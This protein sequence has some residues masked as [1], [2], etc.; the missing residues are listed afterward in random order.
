MSGKV[1]MCANTNA[2][3]EIYKKIVHKFQLSGLGA[4]NK[5][6]I[7]ITAAAS[8]ESI[9]CTKFDGKPGV[10][11]CGWIDAFEKGDK[12]QPIRVDFFIK[13][14]SRWRP[15][16]VFANISKTDYKRIIAQ[17]PQKPATFQCP[18]KGKKL[19][20]NPCIQ[21]GMGILDMDLEMYMEFLKAACED[22]KAKTLDQ[23]QAEDMLDMETK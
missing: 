4:A 7:K 2:F 23:R 6:S 21:G 15:F 13:L 9:E 5:G 10:A 14:G 19:V 17:S 18:N 3:D 12:I 1:Y 8:A 20:F 11:G 16:I 22:E